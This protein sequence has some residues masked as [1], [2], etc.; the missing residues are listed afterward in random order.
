MLICFNRLNHADACMRTM[1]ASCSCTFV[2]RGIRKSSAHTNLWCKKIKVCY[3]NT[4]TDQMEFHFHMRGD[5]HD[6]VEYT[7]HMI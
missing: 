7:F 3:V 4:E 2:V 1:R 6:H 5:L